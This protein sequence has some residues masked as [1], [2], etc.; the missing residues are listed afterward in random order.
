MPEEVDLFV[1]KF[2]LGEEGTVTWDEFHQGITEMR[3][4]LAAGS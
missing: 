2:N 3:T 1:T 4:N